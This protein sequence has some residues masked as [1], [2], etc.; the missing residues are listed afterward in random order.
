MFKHFK[1][2]LG[3]QVESDDFSANGYLFS[4]EKYGFLNT[5]I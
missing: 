3:T 2:N 1:Y 5:I 4:V